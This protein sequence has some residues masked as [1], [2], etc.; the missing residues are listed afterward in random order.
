M[1]V[2][3]W[4][5]LRAPKKV[6]PNSRPGCPGGRIAESGVALA[7]IVGQMDVVTFPEMRSLLI[8]V[9]MLTKLSC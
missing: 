1:C 9:L 3:H 5:F 4:P 2:W 8:L 7:I 6:S